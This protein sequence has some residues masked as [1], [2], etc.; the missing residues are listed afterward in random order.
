MDGVG[1]AELPVVV[2]PPTFGIP[3]LLGALPRLREIFAR[4]GFTS[5]KIFPGLSV[6]NRNA[7]F[8]LVEDGIPW[9]DPHAEDSI[10]REIKCRDDVH[11]T[12]GIR[13]GYR[14]LTTLERLDKED[15]EEIVS[16]AI[17]LLRPVDRVRAD[18]ETQCGPNW[19]WIK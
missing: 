18:L 19:F 4:Y 3:E 15:T 9:D 2:D 11:K 7:F 8:C 14:S 1:N 6:V 5:A 10:E 13:I 16:K 17:E 12:M